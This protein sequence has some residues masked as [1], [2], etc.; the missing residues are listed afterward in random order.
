MAKIRASNAK[1]KTKNNAKIN[2]KDSN[3]NAQKHTSQR[4]IDTARRLFATS[5]YAGTSIRFI[6]KECGVN[7]SMIS[8]YFK[9]KEGLY[10]A[11]L[12]EQIDSVFAIMNEAQNSS[13]NPQVRLQTYIT[14]VCEMYASKPNFARLALSELNGNSSV[15]ERIRSEFASRLLSF[16]AA[17]LQEGAQQGIFRDD[18]SLADMIFSLVGIVHFYLLGFTNAKKMVDNGFKSLESSAFGN[19]DSKTPA[20]NINNCIK[21]YFDGI[22]KNKI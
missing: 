22:S 19:L 3:P 18:I 4:L 16:I 17:N 1:I 5:G 12:Q 6:S 11:V 21:I 8:Y 15:G 13:N 7:L 20:L 2:K 9:N 14:K 10:A